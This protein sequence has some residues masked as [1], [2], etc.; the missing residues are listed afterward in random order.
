MLV[1]AADLGTNTF[2]LLLADVAGGHVRELARRRVTVRLGEGLAAA[3]RLRPAAIARGLA[4]LEGF[5]LLLADWPG[6]RLRAFGTEALRRAANRDAF[7][8]P[9]AGLLG[10]PVEVLPGA[11]EARFSLRGALLGLET[12]CTAPLWL[13]DVGGGSSELVLAGAEAATQSPAP[14]WVRSL[15]LGA[16]VLSEAFAEPAAMRRHIARELVGVLP[17]APRRPEDLLLATGGS[18]S[19]MACLHLGLERY[20]RE[21]VHGLCLD[22]ADLAALEERLTRLGAAERNAL[23]CLGDGRGEILPAGIRIYQALLEALQRP[24]LTVSESGFL[25]GALLAAAEE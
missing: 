18:A 21:R 9:A 4:A 25:E 16:V 17:R 12:D 8:L 11:V 22:R 1:A 15:P 6:C 2:R 3:G 7:L 13:A 10:C 23:P 20:A 14:L 19:A 24:A 5:R